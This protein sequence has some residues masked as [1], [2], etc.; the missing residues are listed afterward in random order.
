[1]DTS[2]DLKEPHFPNASL[3]LILFFFSSLAAKGCHFAL[4]KIY[5]ISFKQARKYRLKFPEF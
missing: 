1:M 4:S 3:C 5:L 2:K